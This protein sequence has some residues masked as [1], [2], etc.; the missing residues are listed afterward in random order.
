M[1]WD[2]NTPSGYDNKSDIGNF[3][4][5]LKSTLNT[6][7]QD[8]HDWDGAGLVH[9]FPISSATSGYAGQIRYNSVTRHFEYYSGSAWV[10]FDHIP[11]GTRM[12]FGNSAAPTGW[13]RVSDAGDVLLRVRGSGNISTGGSWSSVSSVSSAG[14]HNHGGTT[15]TA[16][17]GSISHYWTNQGYSGSSVQAVNSISAHS[18]GMDHSHTVDA[19]TFDFPANHTHTLSASTFRPAYMNIMICERDYTP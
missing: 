7:V 19:G 13:T 6:A 16:T 3:L 12:L 5:S 4:R 8:E 14:S 17:F 9:K 15:G 18:S 11:N 10:V 2:I 1:T